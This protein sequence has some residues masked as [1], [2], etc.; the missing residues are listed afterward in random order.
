M[1]HMQQQAWVGWWKYT[2]ANAEAQFGVCKQATA[3]VTVT[4]KPTT[5]HFA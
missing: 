1:G 2:M 5:L 3:L 4:A